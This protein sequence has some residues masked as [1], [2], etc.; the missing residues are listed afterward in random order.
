MVVGEEPILVEIPNSSA[1]NLQALEDKYG[2][3]LAR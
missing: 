1:K 2:G 3:F